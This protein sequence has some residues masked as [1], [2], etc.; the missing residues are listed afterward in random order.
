MS[1]KAAPPNRV[2]GG[3]RRGT[4]LPPNGGMD[5]RGATAYSGIWASPGVNQ[6]SPSTNWSRAWKE[7]YFFKFISLVEIGDLARAEDVVNIL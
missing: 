6:E 5:R 3:R 4:A 2:P 1:V 7:S